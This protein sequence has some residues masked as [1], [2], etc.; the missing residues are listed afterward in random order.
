MGE[1]GIFGEDD[2][3]ELLEGEIYD[4]SPIGDP[5]AGAV[6]RSTESFVV[7]LVGTAFMASIQNPIRLPN[8]SEPQPDL[9][10]VRRSVRGVADAADVLLVVE[11]ADS[12]RAYDRNKKLPLHAAADIPEVW[13]VDL[14]AETIER[15]TDPRE[16]RYRQLLTVGR[17]ERLSATALPNLTIAVD[18]ILG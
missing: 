7:Q 5:H 3:V 17:G 11:V 6:N 8:N 14:V 4:M 18:D 13:L 10:V 9:A 1:A 16:G 2:R 15:Y 12:S